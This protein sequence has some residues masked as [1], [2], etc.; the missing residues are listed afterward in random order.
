VLSV[1][2]KSQINRFG[3]EIQEIECQFAAGS[4]LDKRMHAVKI[5]LNIFAISGRIVGPLNPPKGDFVAE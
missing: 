1:N 2:L 5:I 4:D 3:V